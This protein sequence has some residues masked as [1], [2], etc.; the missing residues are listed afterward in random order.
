[1]SESKMRLSANALIDLLPEDNDTAIYESN[2]SFRV[3]LRYLDVLDA[4][5]EAGSRPVGLG[6]SGED[7]RI[8]ILERVGMCEDA[9]KVFLKTVRAGLGV[10]S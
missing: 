5:V 10:Q 4:E 2:E 8:R 1:M 3:F 7:N 6:G 9:M